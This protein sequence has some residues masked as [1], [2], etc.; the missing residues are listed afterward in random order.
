[1][2]LE[3]SKLGYSSQS[4]LNMDDFIK[5]F[6]SQSHWQVPIESF[7]EA[8]CLIFTPDEEEIAREEM[9][10]R[11]KIFSDYKKLIMEIL[12][13][14]VMRRH[15][16]AKFSTVLGAL[17]EFFTDDKF[18][19]EQHVFDTLKYLLAVEDFKVFTVFMEDMNIILN[20]QS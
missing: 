16:H 14:T 13:D 15:K 8:Y 17:G 5:L 20:D 3:E 19:S 7:I 6:K 11:L 2:S 9:E 12:A 1:M 10:E 4:T 18:L